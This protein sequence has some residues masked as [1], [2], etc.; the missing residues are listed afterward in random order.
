M[1][2]RDFLRDKGMLL[3]LHLICMCTAAIF[4]RLTDYSETNTILFLIVWLLLLTAWLSVT[5]WQRRRFFLESMEILEKTDQRYLLGELLPDSFRLED[6]LYRDMIR[7]SNKSCIERVR[8]I[9]TERKDYKEYIESWVHEIKAPITGI[10]LLCSNRR[11]IASTNPPSSQLSKPMSGTSPQLSSL[12]SGTRHQ[13]SKP[14]SGTSLQLSMP[15]S[16][17]SP[18]LSNSA[19][20]ISPQL[21]KPAS[22]IMSQLSVQAQP[23]G[24]LHAEIN[25]AGQNMADAMSTASETAFNLQNDYRT[26]SL[27]IQKIENYVDMVLYYAR[28]E[29]VYKDYFIRET[30]LE[31][32]VYEALD[33]N[34]LALIQNQVQ[35]DVNCEDTVYTDRKWI[36]F[37]LNQI[38]LNSIK[39]RGKQP[40]LHICSKREEGHVLLLVEDN[41]VGIRPEELSRIFEKGFTGSNGRENQRSTG[42]GLYLCKTLCRKLGIGLSAE[43][44]Y[45]SGTRLCLEFPVS[46][47]I[48]PH[49]LTKS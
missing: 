34:R 1:K 6:R 2:L 4:F 29:D 14:M 36:V 46:N 48:M 8:Q 22:G 44:E 16:C 21:S 35:A 17:T 37:I 49:I 23:F 28:S 3:L 19:S 42:I 10:S 43:S 39:Y 24:S 32:V 47:Y 27:E 13:L 25:D 11:G 15:M 33:K 40:M 7:R 5:F 45:G 31:D 12:A 38:L 30:T 26:I 20:G 9:E 18:Q 41:G